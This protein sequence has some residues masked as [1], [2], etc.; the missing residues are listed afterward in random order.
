MQSN[1]IITANACRGQC[2]KCKFAANLIDRQMSGVDGGGVA[3]FFQGL[4]L[5]DT[6]HTLERSILYFTFIAID[7]WVVVDHV[8]SFVHH[9]TG[10][11]IYP[12]STTRNISHLTNLI[13]P[14]DARYGKSITIPLQTY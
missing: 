10:Q 4:N 7:L 3:L 2:V 6:L 5:C 1:N 9:C 14:S 12:M 13:I 8:R 11:I